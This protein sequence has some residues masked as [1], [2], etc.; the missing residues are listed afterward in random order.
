M[1][2]DSP[3]FNEFKIPEQSVFNISKYL[4]KREQR[5]LFSIAEF[6]HDSYPIGL[7]PYHSIWL[8][9]ERRYIGIEAWLRDP[10]QKKR[11][12][13]EGSKYNLNNITFHPVELGGYGCS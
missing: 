11:S 3:Q 7:N 12:S 4:A 6:G 13:I 5:K 1:A 8:T 10:F 9:G 2:L